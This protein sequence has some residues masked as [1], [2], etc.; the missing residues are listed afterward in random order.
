M[1][2][3]LLVYRQVS[4]RPSTSEVF[5]FKPTTADWATEAGTL[6]T[7]TQLSMTNRVLDPSL[8]FRTRLLPW[9]AAL[10]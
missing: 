6:V 4:L 9:H 10:R 1:P 2:A 5:D 8:A 7:G 3:R